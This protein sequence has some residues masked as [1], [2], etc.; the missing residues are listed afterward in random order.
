MPDVEVTGGIVEIALAQ[1]GEGIA[2]CEL[3]R[4]FVK[5]GDMVDEFAPVC[6]VQS[7]KASVVITSRYKGQVSQI[8]FNPGD[9]VK[10]GETL[11]ELML[12]GS[13]AASADS[14]DG[15]ANPSSEKA[16][17][18]APEA[19]LSQTSSSTLAAP[20]V[21]ALAKEY[22]VD[23][24]DVVGSGSDGR[25]T[26]GDVMSYISLRE[27]AQDDIQSMTEA[28]VDIEQVPRSESSV[29]KEYTPVQAAPNY[30]V[31]DGGDTS[32]PVRGYRRA[33]AKAMTA[34]AAVPHFYY[35]E[36]IGVKKL[37]M[38]KRAL[39]EGVQLEPGVKLTHLPFLVKALSMA[40]KKYPVMN[41]TVDEAV[42]EIQVR[43]SHNIGIAMATC[44]GL[45]VPNI[46][47]VQRLSV[48][49][50]ATELSRLI[51]L[52]NTNSLS[53]VDITGG[54]ITVSNFGAIGGKCGMPILNVPE[55][56]IV[57]IGR[58]QQVVR[59]NEDYSEFS[60]EPV[61]N[62]TWGADHRVIDGATVAHFCNEWKLLIEQPERLLL[63]LQ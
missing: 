24:A 60:S 30:G 33:M 12:E 48:L 3:I 16:S 38:L 10:V 59:S 47:N 39:S 20:A 11:L 25:I 31:F 35:V 2:D 37:T 51:Q 4:W 52:A 21:R 18:A 63:T 55:V 13:A 34:A 36:E 56:A 50:I 8:R 61:V 22:G 5:E 23:L 32:I 15:E 54:T 46:K 1:T 29:D 19:R 44:H 26:K 49:E 14:G 7:D 42:T 57:A 45:V 6:E 41:S 62:V 43:A 40:L 28:P 9:I 17:M 58:M 53:T 27:N